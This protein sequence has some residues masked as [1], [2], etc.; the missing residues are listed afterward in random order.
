[1]SYLKNSLRG[2]LVA[3]LTLTTIGTAPARAGD[4]DA[5][6]ALL[7]GAAT[8]AIISSGGKNKPAPQP[9]HQVDRDRHD[10]Y[11]L[12]RRNSNHRE[13]LRKRW[14]DKGWVSFYDNRCLRNLTQP[15]PVR[16]AAK[17]KECLRKRWTEDGWVKFYNQRCLRRYEQAE[18]R[19]EPRRIKPKECLRQEWSKD[20]WQKFYSKVCL[21]KHG[22]RD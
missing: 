7:F 16:P 5:L 10:G 22:Y 17:P 21:R 12:D 3:A 15:A 11:R 2:T 8:V 13:C 9:V 4:A 20:G 1:M 18:V 14:T 19:P 6:A